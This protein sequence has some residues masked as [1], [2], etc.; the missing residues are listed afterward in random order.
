MTT[1]VLAVNF[2]VAEGL[3]TPSETLLALR[4]LLLDAL[5]HHANVVDLTPQ[6]QQLA[7]ALLNPEDFNEKYGRGGSFPNR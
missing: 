3:D 6:E 4:T 5:E 1:K 7:S 2:N